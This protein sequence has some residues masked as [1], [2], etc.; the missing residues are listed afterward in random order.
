MDHTKLVICFLIIV[1]G[2][3]A[4]LGSPITDDYPGEE[5]ELSPNGKVNNRIHWSATLFMFMMIVSL[6]AQSCFS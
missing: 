3:I 4:T 1:L 2:A 6:V 5:T